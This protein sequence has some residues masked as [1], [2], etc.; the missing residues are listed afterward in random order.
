[1]LNTETQV[2][3]VVSSLLRQLL[4]FVAGLL[5]SSAW[6]AD[7]SPGIEVGIAVGDITPR[8]PVWLSPYS[9]ERPADKVD[10]PLTA[11]AIAFRSGPDERIV[12]VAVDNAA[13]RRE[14]LR[15]VLSALASKYGLGPGQVMIVTS[16]SH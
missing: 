13:V 6:A 16:H 14:F 11:T 8:G 1:M 3:L 10:S 15:P 12:M 2:E 4:V 5:I 7:S 9:R